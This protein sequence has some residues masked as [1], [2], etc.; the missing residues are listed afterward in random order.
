MPRHYKPNQEPNHQKLGP[1]GAKPLPPPTPQ[2]VKNFFAKVQKTESCW[3]WTGYID[4]MGYGSFGYGHKPRLAHRVSLVI[5]GVN[6][7][8]GMAVDHLCMNPRCVNPAHLRLV[9]P[10]VSST[11]NCN[12]PWV[13]NA[14]KPACSKGHPFTPE[15]TALYVPPKCRTRH[16]TIKPNTRPTR[17]CLTC[18]PHYWRWAIVPRDPPPNSRPWK[19]RRED[20]ESAQHQSAGV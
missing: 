9:T 8:P 6:L 19:W 17:V 14:R 2:Q 12:S 13:L 18:W 1:A 10:R 5:A 3:L 7:L 20:G 15:N 11:E 4:K 16:G